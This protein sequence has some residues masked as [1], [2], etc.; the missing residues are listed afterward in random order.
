MK[1]LRDLNIWRRVSTPAETVPESLVRQA[2]NPVIF[3]ALRKVFIQAVLPTPPSCKHP[4]RGSFCAAAPRTGCEDQRPHKGGH[5]TKHRSYPLH[6]SSPPSYLPITAPREVIH[7][8]LASTDCCFIAEQSA[9]AP[10][11]AHPEGCAALRIASKD[12]RRLGR[13][14]VIE[15]QFWTAVGFLQARPVV[16]VCVCVRVREREKESER[17]SVCV[18]ERERVP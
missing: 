12:T 7:G 6:R 8:W 4:H 1:D 18:S 13:F 14:H 10:H 15:W 16:C 3:E 5:V 17:E 9:P 2:R 11:L